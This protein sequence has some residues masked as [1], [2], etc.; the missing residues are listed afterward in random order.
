MVR[1]ALSGN[2]G[3]ARAERRKWGNLDLEVSRKDTGRRSESRRV[4]CCSFQSL[5]A[6]L[7]TSAQLRGI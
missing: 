4:V 2:D 6:S 1:A 5:A 3:V 7:S